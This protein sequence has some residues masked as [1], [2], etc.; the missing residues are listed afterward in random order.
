[1]GRGEVCF[2]RGH[3]PGRT[4]LMHLCPCLVCFRLNTCLRLMLTT[5]METR[6]GGSWP[7]EAGILFGANCRTAGWR[8]AGTDPRRRRGRHPSQLRRVVR[9][10]GSCL[11]IP[12]Q[13][14]RMVVLGWARPTLV[15]LPGLAA[16]PPHRVGVLHQAARRPVP[17]ARPAVS[18]SPAVAVVAAFVFP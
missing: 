17:R 14:D 7:L 15:P 8:G 4:T 1:M 18:V 12:L 11:T 16:G 3:P 2:E 13:P 9:V 10:R 6:A 5:P